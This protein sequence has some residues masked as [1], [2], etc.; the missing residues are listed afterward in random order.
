M[1][2]TLVTLAALSFGASVGSAAVQV[3]LQNFDLTNP[4]SGATPLVDNTGVGINGSWAAG[5]VA[6]PNAQAVSAAAVLSA[7]TQNPPIAGTTGQFLAADA[8]FSQLGFV[9]QALSDPATSTDGTDQFF[10]NPIWIIIGNDPTGLATSTDFILY[11]S[12]T[13]W[14]IEITGVGGTANV[15]IQLPSSILRRGVGQAFTY[16]GTPAGPFFGFYATGTTGVTFIPE[17]TTSLLAGL[18]GLGLLVRRRR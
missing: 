10:N 1:K 8:A 7:F 18:A 5:I 14:P 4:G 16:T 17:P 9:N 12:A 11:E 3:T 6:V 2:N 13:L 15:Q